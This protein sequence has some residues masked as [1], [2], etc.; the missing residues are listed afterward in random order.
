MKI[1]VRKV[2]FNSKNDEVVEVIEG[3]AL[4]EFEA[5]DYAFDNKYKLCSGSATFFRKSRN[6]VIYFEYK[7]SN[8]AVP[9]NRSLYL[10]YMKLKG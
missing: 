6:D 7:L 1:F 4:S 2:D 3:S 10:D 5:F 8:D 9:E